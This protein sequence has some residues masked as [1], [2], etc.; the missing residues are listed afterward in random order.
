MKRRTLTIV[1]GLLLTLSLVGVGFASWVITAGDTE[2]VT[3]NINVENVVDQRLELS[4]VKIVT[5]SAT[6]DKTSFVFG[7]GT[8]GT[9]SWLSAD[10]VDAE[11][12]SATLTFDLAYKSGTAIVLEDEGKNVSLSVA[13]DAATKTL[14]EN[15]VT[16]GY[17]KAVPA[18][19]VEGSAG[20]YSVS[21]VFEWGQLFN[22]K[23]PF[24]WYNDHKV[25]DELIYD[26]NGFEIAEGTAKT[27]GDHAA[28]FLGKLFDHFNGQKYTIVIDAQ[29]Y[30]A[31]A[32]A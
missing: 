6:A 12:L 30:T 16:A 1:V 22:N 31:P 10:D 27:Y 25:D 8:Q 7:K 14:L 9:N 5:T 11:V 18:L 13:F 15:A 29:P 24:K 26:A 19:T 4:N 17:I 21:I 3:G 20:S 28:E 32:Q 23:N 2:T